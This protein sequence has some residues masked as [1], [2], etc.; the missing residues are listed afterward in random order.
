MTQKRSCGLS[1]RIFFVLH[2][3]AALGAHA[4][5]FM[6][7]KLMTATGTDFIQ[8]ILT[9]S[10][11]FIVGFISFYALFFH[12]TFHLSNVGAHV[13]ITVP[14]HFFFHI[15]HF[16][17]LA[18]IIHLTVVWF[19]VLAIAFVV[20]HSVASSLYLFLRPFYKGGCYILC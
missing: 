9:Y 2:G 4:P 6:V 12:F 16:V 17:V 11:H 13:R 14:S 18:V 7:V 3:N 5:M 8:T 1:R 19:R 15:G 20:I 10:I